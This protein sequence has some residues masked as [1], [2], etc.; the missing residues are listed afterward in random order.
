MGW[1]KAK[2]KQAMGSKKEADGIALHNEELKERGR[3]EREQARA[4]AERLR[5]NARHRHER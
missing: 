1:V 5:D 3:R 4:E 2:I